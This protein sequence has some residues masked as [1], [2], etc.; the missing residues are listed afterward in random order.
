VGSLEKC[1]EIR[2]NGVTPAL[3]P[4]LSPRRGGATGRRRK[5]RGPF[6][7]F[8]PFGSTCRTVAAME[9]GD[10][11]SSFQGDSSRVPSP[12]GEGQGEGGPFF[13]NLHPL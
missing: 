7:A 2:K 4:T 13:T 10:L 9:R 8:S 6:S 3:T 11:R 12:G 5:I 1:T